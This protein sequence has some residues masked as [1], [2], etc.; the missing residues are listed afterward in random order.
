MIVRALDENGDFTFG[1]SKADYLSN[2]NSIKQNIRTRL[3]E[4]LGDCFFNITAGIDWL[5][6]LGGSKNVPALKLSISSIILNTVG[7]TGIRQLSINLT[8]DRNFSVSYDADTVYSITSDNFLLSLD[9]FNSNNLQ[10]LLAA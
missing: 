5:T 3:L 7:V 1:K 8:S 6:F 9:S 4:F 10:S 2:L